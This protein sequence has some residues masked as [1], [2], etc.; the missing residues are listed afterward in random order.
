MSDNYHQP[1]MG[2]TGANSIML[3]FGDS[4]FF[5]DANGNPA[6]P[7]EGQL[8]FAG[9]PNAGV[10]HEIE[11]PDPQPGTNNWYT[12]DGYGGGGFGKPVF[13]GGSYSDCSDSDA[14]GV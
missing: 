14:P 12:E 10:V 13:G 9:T 8:V 7:P 6:K 3:G 11:N 4:L 1:V 5:S 2:G